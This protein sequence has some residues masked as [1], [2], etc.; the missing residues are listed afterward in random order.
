MSLDTRTQTL[1]VTAPQ[2]VI[3]RTLP[4]LERQID[5]ALAAKP[6]GLDLLLSAIQIID[7]HGLNWLLSLQAR[8]ESLDVRLRLVDPSAIVADALLA[9]RLDSRF[10]I[11]MSSGL[12]CPLQ[13]DS[14]DRPAG[15]H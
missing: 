8:L 6:Q 13:L 7:S 15:A 2:Q 4:T 11:H 1:P 5:D 9:T 12:A 14:A 3:Q 10:L